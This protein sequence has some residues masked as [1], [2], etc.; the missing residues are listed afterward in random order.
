[1]DCKQAELLMMQHFDH[2][3]HLSPEKAQDLAKHILICKACR[4]IYLTFDEI[5]ET[6]ESDTKQ[7]ANTPTGFTEA[8]MEKV[9]GGLA[10]VRI[11]WGLGAI[12]SGTVL[13]LMYHTEWLTRLSQSHPAID[14]TISILAS[15]GGFFRNVSERLQQGITTYTASNYG[16]F[17]LA[18]V[19]L[20]GTLLIVLH[21]GEKVNT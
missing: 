18:I 1:M 14:T 17:A 19:A 21:N 11:L 10:T 4:E 16:V 2:V 7:I 13:L 12:I 8:V 15:I 5:S 9:R 20:M 6:V 3:E